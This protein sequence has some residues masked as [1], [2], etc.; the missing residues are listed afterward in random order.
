V[1]AKPF[2]VLDLA[3][4]DASIDI[5]V[6]ALRDVEVRLSVAGEPRLPPELSLGFGSAVEAGRRTEDPA[7]GVVRARV[8]PR[9]PAQPGTVTACGSH[10]E[11]RE[12]GFEWPEPGGT[13][14]VSI[15]LTYQARLELLVV[16]AVGKHFHV[17]LERRD[18]D[19]HW[20]KVDGRDWEADSP[21][22]HEFVLD[23]PG[24]Y[25]AVESERSVVSDPVEVRAQ[26]D[27]ARVTI[28]LSKS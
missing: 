14:T 19:G 16:I 2:R 22:S 24:Q 6:G 27:A 23:L 3:A 1:A 26:A 4:G 10:L 5:L 9:D 28:D 13:A 11:R 21:G 15:D 12:E 7:K 25:R 18:A 17:V 20:E 8:R